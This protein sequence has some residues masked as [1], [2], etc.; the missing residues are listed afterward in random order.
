[1][2]KVQTVLGE[3]KPEDLG[4]T[5]THEHLLIESVEALWS[6]PM[7]EYKKQ[8]VD[9]PVQM[10][11][12]GVIRRSPSI[13][14][15][16]LIMNDVDLAVREANEFK[17]VGGR[18]IVDVTTKGIGQNPT[19]LVRISKLTGLNVIAGTGYYVARSH[20]PE[21]KKKSL[22]QLASDFV[23]EITAGIDDSTVK[24]GILGELGVSIK[25]TEEEEKILRAASRASLE[26]GCPISVHFT[27]PGREA[28][29]AVEI[30]EDEGVSPK[31]INMGHLDTNSDI[32]YH[33]RIAEYGSFISYDQ[34]GLQYD[35]WEQV[36]GPEDFSSSNQSLNLEFPRDS[37]RVRMIIELCRAGFQD[38]IL[39]SQDIGEKVDLKFYGGHGYDHILRVIVP[40][41][42]KRGFSKG[43]IDS[44]M[45]DNP[46]KFLTFSG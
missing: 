23:S 39:L 3:I 13:S 29:K 38:Q 9:Q 24:C 28:F 26:T 30:F 35:D 21:V 25:M 19:A 41:F 5:L 46:R 45:I 7:D 4:I 40:M 15:D 12:L 33:K 11:N 10:S 32:E 2:S 42:L 44:I 27:P 16:N 17:N 22:D 36:A 20:P 1:M 6:E 18:S 34:F 43:A 14:K 8:F 37:E 31:R